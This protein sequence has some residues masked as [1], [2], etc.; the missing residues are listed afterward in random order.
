[1]FLSHKEY[2][3]YVNLLLYIYFYLYNFVSQSLVEGVYFSTFRAAVR[4]RRPWA[5]SEIPAIPS[6]YVGTECSELLR[7]N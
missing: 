2:I 5:K 6:R 1:M 7:Q 3:T 4:L